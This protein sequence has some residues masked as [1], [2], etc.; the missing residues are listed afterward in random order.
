MANGEA[1]KPALIRIWQI[2]REHSDPEH[3]LTQVQ[4]SEYLEDE[5]GLSM[6]RKAIGR[7]LALLR[8]AG[9]GIRSVKDGSYIEERVFEDS[10]LHLLI[11]GIL[12]SKH[13]APAHSKDLIRR[14]CELSSEHFRANSSYIYTVDDRNKT[15]NY[16]LFYTIETIDRAIEMDK[17]VLY[18]YNKYGIDKKMHKSSR[19]CVSPYLMIL[20]NQRYYLM[21]FS[22]KWQHMTFH[23]LDNMSNIEITDYDRRRITDVPGYEDG[24]DVKKLSSALP[25]MYTDAPKQIVMRADTGIIDQIID[26][27]GRDVVISKIPDDPDKV[28]VVVTASPNAMEHWALQYIRFVEVLSPESLRKQIFEA[29]N[30]G[31]NKYR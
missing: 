11:D 23:R 29:I 10:E 19:Q 13:I 16:E 24:I 31:Y 17:Q 14:L 12:C 27:F 8:E 2:L 7:N 25:Y 26:W 20:N 28:K 18:Q 1:K 15:D 4:I 9:M 5:Y 21:G 30:E 22:D 6:E 3:P